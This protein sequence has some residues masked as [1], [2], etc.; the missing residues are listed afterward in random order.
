MTIIDGLQSTFPNVEIILKIFL[1]IPVTNTGVRSFSVLSILSKEVKNYLRNSLGPS[2]F[3][4]LSLMFIKAKMT[5][6]LDYK[7]LIDLFSKGKKKRLELK[8]FKTF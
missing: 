6:S 8:F 4:K 7:N 1:K 3:N 2:K 5:N